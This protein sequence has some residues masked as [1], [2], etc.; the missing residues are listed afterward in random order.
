[1]RKINLLI[2]LLFAAVGLQAQT[3]TYS[4][5]SNLPLF[6]KICEDTF[7][8]YSRLPERVKDSLLAKKREAV[9]SLGR[10]SAGEFIRFSSDAGQF[11]FRW[12][13]SMNK[14]L[15]NMALCGVRGMAL[16]TIDKGQWIYVGTARPR[17]AKGQE[18]YESTINCRKLAGQNCEYMLYLSLYDGIKNLQIGVP[19]GRNLNLPETN[20]P[21]ATKPI[22][23]YGTSILQGASASHPGMCSTNQL[24]RRLNRV[25]INLGFSGNALLDTEIAE[26]MAAYPDPG[27]FVLD[28]TPNGSPQMTLEKEEAFFRILRNAHPTVPV[29]FVGM[30]MYPGGRFDEKR[31]NMCVEREKAMKSVY[32]KLVKSGEKNIYFVPGSKLLPKDNVGTI[33]GTHFTDI[34]FTQYT[35]VLAPVLKKI[36]NGR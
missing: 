18:Y 9:W 31:E 8:P 28:N 15:D 11:S 10:A 1:M 23:M 2:L 16:Y 34:G 19:E 21:L 30:P 5:A 35:D 24:S 12:Y 33:E 32:D 13:T 25:V 7:E 6:G 4:D 14:T 17:F 29:V 36:M 3:F 22:I 27:V 26:L 20:S